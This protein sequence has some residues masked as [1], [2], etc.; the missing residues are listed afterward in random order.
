VVRPEDIELLPPEKGQIAGRVKNVTFMGVHN[1][2]TVETPG[3][4]WTVH[5]IYNASVGDRVGIYL[6]PDDIHIMHKS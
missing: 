3:F 6:T 1:E 5:S 2:I 4:D